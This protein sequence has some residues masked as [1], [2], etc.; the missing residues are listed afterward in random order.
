MLSKRSLLI[1]FFLLVGALSAASDERYYLVFLKPDPARKK[2]TD[3]EAEKI[4]AA[5]MA[6]I[7]K[8]AEEE[9]LVAAGPFEDTPRT[10]SGAFVFTKFHSIEEAM[11]RASEDPTVKAHRNTVETHVWHAPSGIGEEYRK[12]HKSDPSTPENMQNHPV[13]FLYKGPRWADN[14]EAG[15]RIM[16][17]H[18]RY[19]KQLKDEGHLAAAGYM[20]SGDDLVYI[21]VFKVIPDLQARLLLM[22]DAAISSGFLRSEEHH[23]WIADHVMPW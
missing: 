6:N 4:Q 7:K 1:L 23:W 12:L 9:V 5:H 3:A 22:G 2:I 20:N 14:S 17:Q 8:M 11:T 19:L 15:T 18:D 10:I 21:V 16:D 13:W